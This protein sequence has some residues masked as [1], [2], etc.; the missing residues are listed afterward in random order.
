MKRN[1][2]SYLFIVFVSVV[3][4]ACKSKSD[5]ENSTWKFC[6]DRRSVSDIL[7]FNKE[8]LYVKNDSLFF[9]RNDSLIGI[10]DTIKMHYGERRLYVK[11]LKGNVGRYCE[12]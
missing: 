3:L 6:G 9:H 11:D 7:I 2:Y 10:I 5:L 4:V 1:V 12:K 8:M